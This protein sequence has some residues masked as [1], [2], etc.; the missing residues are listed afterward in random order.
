MKCVRCGSAIS[1]GAK[2]CSR[3]GCQCD[4]NASMASSS[5]KPRKSRLVAGLVGVCAAGLT[6]VAVLFFGMTGSETAT[7]AENSDGAYQAPPA[8]DVL[9]DED[10]E[11]SNVEGRATDD[12]PVAAT[13][14]GVEI[15]ESTIAD[16]VAQFRL[17]SDLIE[18]AAWV[19]WM[20]DNE[21]DPEIVR[22]EA[23]IV[24]AD[25][26]EGLP[27]DIEMPDM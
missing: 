7:V 5:R 19:S 8:E 9:S 4:G 21:W 20:Q 6:V 22:S 27:Y 2:F 17:D 12:S 15:P 3:C 18:D 26:P 25:M 14:N 16:Y 10:C 13:V 1:D 11:S 24:R 23:E